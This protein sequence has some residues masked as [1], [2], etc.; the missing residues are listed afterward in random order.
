MYVH[1]WHGIDS[2]WSPDGVALVLFIAHRRMH[3]C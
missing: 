2:S 3:V 1:A